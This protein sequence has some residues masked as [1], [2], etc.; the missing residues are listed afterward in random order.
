MKHK[1]GAA[2]YFQKALS[3]RKMGLESPGEQSITRLKPEMFFFNFCQLLIILSSESYLI[4]R[5]LW[6][7]GQES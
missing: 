2:S 4:A 3:V 1:T 5:D 7:K 6:S